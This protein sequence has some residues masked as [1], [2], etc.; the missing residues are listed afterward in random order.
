ME[1]TVEGWGVQ[2]SGFLKCGTFRELRAVGGL[3]M[4]FEKAT[5]VLLR[6]SAQRWPFNCYPRV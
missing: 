5:E 4:F 2:R 3:G 1:G 6:N